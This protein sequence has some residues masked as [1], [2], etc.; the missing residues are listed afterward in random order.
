MSA[1]AIA[2][3]AGIA[4][5]IALLWRALGLKVSVYSSP[6]ETGYT[7]KTPSASEAA[8]ITGAAATMKEAFAKAGATMT[9]MSLQY[10]LAIA[11]LETSFGKGWSTPEGKASNNW[12]SVQAKAG[13]PSFAWH[14]TYSSGE[15]YQQAF[16][17]YPTPVDGAADVVRHVLLNRKSVERALSEDGASIW[18]ASLAMRRTTYYGS[19][20]KQAIARFGP[21][22]QSS[23][24]NPQTEAELACEKEAVSLHVE[25][26]K[27]KL[28]VIVPVL[29]I[30]ALPLGTY[31][32]AIEWSKGGNNN[33]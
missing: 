5:G 30:A 7:L 12:G 27:A 8:M 25:T 18:R 19:W 32:D 2:I 15:E 21:I 22:K 20:C 16:K 1:R 26:V 28:A 33:A 24:K 3:G 17:T 10:C 4:S 14:D 23:Q 11:W 13:E 31:E 29:G 9:D 6:H